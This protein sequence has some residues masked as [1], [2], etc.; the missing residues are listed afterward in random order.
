MSFRE[1]PFR[2]CGASELHMKLMNELLPELRVPTTRTLE[3]E[4]SFANY[5]SHH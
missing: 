2:A 1:A 4:V 5:Y 3:E